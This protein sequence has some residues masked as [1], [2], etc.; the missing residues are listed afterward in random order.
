MAQATTRRKVRRRSVRR[1]EGRRHPPEPG[2][3]DRDQNATG[4]RRA[5][6]VVVVTVEMRGN[7]MGTIYSDTHTI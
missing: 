3:D 1:F 4:L 7:A 5:C 6:P 2:R